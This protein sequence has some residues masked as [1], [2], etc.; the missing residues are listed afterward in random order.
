MQNPLRNHRA[1][2]R[3]ARG[4]GQR[5]EIDMSGQIGLAGMIQGADLLVTADRLERIASGPP[6]TIVDDQSHS[7]LIGDACAQSGG[8]GHRTG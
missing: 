6:V 8:D 5:L 1:G 4:R 3:G 7:A 2:Q